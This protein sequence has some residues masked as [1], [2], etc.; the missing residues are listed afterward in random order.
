MLNVVMVSVLEWKIL[1]GM[2][3]KIIKQIFVGWRNGKLTKCPNTIESL[4]QS[5]A[6]MPNKPGTFWSRLKDQAIEYSQGPML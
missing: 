2:E 4:N 5:S 6:K 1:I 3:W